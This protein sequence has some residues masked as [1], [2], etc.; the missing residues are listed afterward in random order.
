REVR[1]R[2]LERH[3]KDV[4]WRVLFRTIARDDNHISPHHG[5]D[6]VSISLHHNAGL[7]YDTYFSDIEPI[8]QRYGGRPHWGK[9][10]SL[11]ADELRKLYPE[12]ERFQEVRRNFDK[13]GLFINNYLKEILEV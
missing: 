12:W 5:R 1:R 11:R 2:V 13:R 6:S 9:K 8:F 4:A 3:R 7:P 10:H